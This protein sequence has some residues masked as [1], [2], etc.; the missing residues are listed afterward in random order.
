MAWSPDGC[1][2]DHR[3][4]VYYIANWISSWSAVVPVDLIAYLLMFF[5]I[6]VKYADQRIKETCIM[7]RSLL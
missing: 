1:V 7:L 6:Q 3:E 4:G 2:V 5:S